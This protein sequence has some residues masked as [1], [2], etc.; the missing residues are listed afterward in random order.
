MNMIRFEKYNEKYYQQV[1]DFLIEINKENDYHN[2]WNWARFEWMH[3]H[4]LTNK[5]L[6]N[7]M[8]LWFDDDHLIGATLIDM[9]FG[10]AFVG[11]LFADDMGL[12]FPSL[13][14]NIL[15]FRL[16]G[17][18]GIDGG[19]C[20]LHRGKYFGDCTHTQ[21]CRAVAFCRKDDTGALR[22]A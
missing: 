4:P 13:P 12:L 2:N 21:R 18:A 9:F 20:K 7:E 19:T 8:G 5:E 15:L 17:W 11:V 10:E 6:L 22:A 14:D 16:Y 3:E 1:C